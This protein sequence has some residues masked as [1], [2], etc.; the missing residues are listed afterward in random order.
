MG[1]QRLGKITGTL[2]QQDNFIIRSWQ[3]QEDNFIRN[4]TICRKRPTRD[5]VHDLRVAIKRMRS[6]LRLKQIF[7]GEEWKEF[8]SNISC[9]FKSLGMLRDYDMSLV[10]TRGYLKKEKKNFSAFLYFLNANR[11]LTRQWSREAAAD[12]NEEDIFRL[13]ELF[14]QAMAVFSNEMLFEKVRDVTDEKFRKVNK[15][16]HRFKK[17][18]HSIRKE[19]KDLYYWLKIFPPEMTEPLVPIK[20]LDKLLENLGNWQD[21]LIFRTKLKYFRKE[22]SPMA[23]AAAIDLKILSDDSETKQE[24]L[25]E[26]AKSLW[27]EIANNQDR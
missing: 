13:K 27:K 9:L 14:C 3:E 15:L 10:L 7:T 5:S 25:L 17:N 19:L 1:G 6:Y 11:R 23:N 4:L 8:F 18:A 24:A 2:M 16:A 26:K 12:F 22:F 20:P 21:Q